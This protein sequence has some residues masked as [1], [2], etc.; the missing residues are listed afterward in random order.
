MAYRRCKLCLVLINVPPL[1]VL[2][3]CACMYVCVIII[4]CVVCVCVCVC[5][6]VSVS[7]CVSVFEKRGERGW[8]RRLST[9]STDGG[10]MHL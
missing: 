7:V 9:V 2:C 5:V 10:Y 1:H 3:M 6:C 4:M 8:E